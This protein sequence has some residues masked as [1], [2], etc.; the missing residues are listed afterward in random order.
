VTRLEAHLFDWSGDLYGQEI[1]VRLHAF[2]RPDTTF[3]GLDE[4]KAAITA[5][6]AAAR[7]LLG[8]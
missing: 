1:G 7:R 6:A 3:A 4:L 2:I 5:D 8:A